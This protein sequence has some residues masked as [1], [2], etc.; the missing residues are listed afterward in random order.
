MKILVTPLAYVVQ[1][2]SIEICITYV[3]H[4]GMCN[5]LSKNE[6][7]SAIDTDILNKLLGDHI[8]KLHITK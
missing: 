3:N 7:F 8:D 4:I 5:T 1:R 6:D 2:K